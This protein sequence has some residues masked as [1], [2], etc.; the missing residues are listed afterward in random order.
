[1][2]FLI[3]CLSK[4]SKQYFDILIIL[5]RKNLIQYSKKY[6]DFYKKNQPAFKLALANINP[7]FRHLVILAKKRGPRKKTKTEKKIII[8]N[9]FV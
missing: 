6:E 7:D 4:T 1:M 8:L 3:F 9:K 2:S 5:S